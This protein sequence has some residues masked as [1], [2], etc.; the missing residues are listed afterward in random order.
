VSAADDRKVLMTIV[1]DFNSQES[2]N[3]EVARW[4]K[5]EADFMDNIKEKVQRLGVMLHN[6]NK[7]AGLRTD[8]L[9]K[10][11]HEIAM[12]YQDYGVAYSTRLSLEMFGIYLAQ[13]P[14]KEQ[15]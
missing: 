11:V 13:E 8:M 12:A 1:V 14:E 10:L 9:H 4:T 5:I 3:S 15:R 6:A 2:I 7:S